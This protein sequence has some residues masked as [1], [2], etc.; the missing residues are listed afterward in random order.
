MQVQVKKL[1]VHL[2]KLGF[3]L[4]FD[5]Q[6]LTPGSIIYLKT[7]TLKQM[8]EQ[9]RHLTPGKETF[10]HVAFEMKLECL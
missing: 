2:S 1:Q 5:C 9:I 6:K 3:N 8:I 4:S 10:I 7:K